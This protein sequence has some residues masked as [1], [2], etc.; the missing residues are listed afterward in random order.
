MTSA[1]SPATTRSEKRR[2]GD[3]F[4]DRFRIR[5]WCLTSTDSATTERAP[6]GPASR[7]TVATRCRKRTAR[8]RTAQSYKI[9]A[10]ARVSNEFWNSPWTRRDRLG[11]LLHE[12]ERAA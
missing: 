9:A 12:Y 10:R 5:S 1:H 6:P 2:L 4:R 7:E 3:R 11:G 8:S